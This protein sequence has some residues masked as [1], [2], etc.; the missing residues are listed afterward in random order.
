[1]ICYGKIDI[2]KYGSMKNAYS[3]IETA[4]R[5]NC[6]RSLPS[7]TKTLWLDALK[8][9]IPEQ[10]IRKILDLGCGTG[11]FTAVLGK[12]FEC[13][14]VGVEPSSAMLGVANSQSEPNVEWKQGQAENIPLENQAVDLVFMSQVF[15]HLS[16]PQKALQE[17]NRVL[18][19]E[20]Y[21]AIRNGTREYN[22]DLKWLEFF[23]EALEIE[24]KRTPSQPE[25]K[26][27][28]YRGSFE[29]ISQRTIYQ[30]FAASYDEYFEKVS[31]RGLSALIVISDK[32]FQ[33][34]LQRFQ[35]WVSR[36]P[37]EQ[38][39]YEPV[40]LFVFQKRAA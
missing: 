19:S 36:Q 21:L 17:I 14:V 25:L 31:L 38:P 33:S 23:P 16:E 39:V 12:A 8:S 35:N 3:Q 29:L 5:Y 37:R 10:K 13:S 24:N 2:E 30:L 40:D 7:Q 34:G 28:V 27:S 20:G 11:R 4:N 9:S 26:E 32:A 18:S 1:M 15:H 22:K 6:A